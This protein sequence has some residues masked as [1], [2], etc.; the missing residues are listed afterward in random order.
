MDS[1]APQPAR[2]LTPRHPLPRAGEG[3]GEAPGR[4][5]LT[6]SRDGDG[7]TYLDRQFAGY[8]F[9]VCRPHYFPHDVPGMATLYVQSS[10]GGLYQ[11][12]AHEIEIMANDGTRAHVTTRRRP[13]C[14]AWSA[15][16]AVQ[17]TTVTAGPGSHVEVVPD[18]LILFPAATL[19]TTLRVRVHDTATAVIAESFLMHDPDSVD[20]AFESFQAEAVV[21]DWDGANL[22]VDRFRISGRDVVAAM[23]G[24]TGAA[25]AQGL[26]MVVG[27]GV[28]QSGLTA[29][30]RAELG[31]HEDVFGG[32]SQLPNAAGVSVRLLASDGAALRAAMLAAWESASGTLTGVR[33]LP[34]RK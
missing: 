23:P 27:R 14:T 8:P 33:P 31:V 11:E 18:P 9:H 21:G 4:L 16:G 30:L 12:D 26:L 28:E 5:S 32:V 25:R 1:V 24:I 19:S 13:S 15:G 34:R 20:A 10:A 7:R 2:G 6:F 29:A 22:A 17:R 3:Q